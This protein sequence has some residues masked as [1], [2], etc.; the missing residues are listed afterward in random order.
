M[1]SFV[2]L[3]K[4]ARAT[5]INKIR[6]EQQQQHSV[7]IKLGTFFFCMSTRISF[8]NLFFSFSFLVSL[9]ILVS[10]RLNLL[11]AFMSLSLPTNERYSSS[12]SNAPM[13]Q[14]MS[15]TR[16]TQLVSHLLCVPLRVPS[17]TNLITTNTHTH[18][19]HKRKERERKKENDKH[20]NRNRARSFVPLS[21][22][23]S[24]RMLRG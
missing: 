8:E 6:P 3:K 4:K 7:G 23:P 1:T 5:R 24:V 17:P 12:C 9:L 11:C 20:M 21:V 2:P 15:Q 18:R 16:N 13:L 10:T 14:L 22:C 19:R